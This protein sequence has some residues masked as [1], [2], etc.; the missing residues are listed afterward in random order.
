MMTQ[1]VISALQ[2]YN[3]VQIV[4]SLGGDGHSAAISA[5]GEVFTWC[6]IILKELGTV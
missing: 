2:G 6:V 4:T 1:T 3:I 5:D